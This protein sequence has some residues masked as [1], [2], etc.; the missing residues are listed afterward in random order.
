MHCIH[1]KVLFYKF[2]LAIRALLIVVCYH[3]T[4]G[5]IPEKSPAVRIRTYISELKILVELLHHFTGIIVFHCE[6]SI[7]ASNKSYSGKNKT[8]QA[9][10]SDAGH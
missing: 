6:K 9:D 1:K 10:K 4:I 2:T 3:H 5:K 7:D 8:N